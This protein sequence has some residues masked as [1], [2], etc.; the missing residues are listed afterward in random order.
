MAGGKG[1][2]GEWGEG[3]KM[4]GNSQPM[5]CENGS[6]NEKVLKR[7]EEL[8]RN[9]L[10]LKVTRGCAMGQRAEGCRWWFSDAWSGCSVAQPRLPI[11]C[12]SGFDFLMSSTRGRGW[13]RMMVCIRLCP[14][15]TGLMFALLEDV[16]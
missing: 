16:G 1:G 12:L 13:S 10:L 3:G 7:K 15:T 4:P 9:G 14:V 5:Q 11:Q 6:I 2:K 8:S